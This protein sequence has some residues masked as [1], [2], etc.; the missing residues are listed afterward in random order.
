GQ[1][2]GCRVAPARAQEDVRRRVSGWIRLTPEP[3]SSGARARLRDFDFRQGEPATVVI[4]IEQPRQSNRSRG[5]GRR[6]AMIR[7]S[8]VVLTASLAGL[9]LAPPVYAAGDDAGTLSPD[10]AAKAFAS[11]PL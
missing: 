4:N 10:K 6:F 2:A 9:F 5:K 11:K 3:I 7:R 1:G 8:A